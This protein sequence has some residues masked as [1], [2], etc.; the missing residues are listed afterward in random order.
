MNFIEVIGIDVSKK[1]IDA[2]I[3]VSGRSKEFKNT[4]RGLHE[5]LNWSKRHVEDINAV[6][7]VFE[8]TGM[9]S[10]LI[11]TF[12]DAKGCRYFVAPALEIKRSMGIVRGKDDKVD[13]KRIALY[14]F[15]L[16]DELVPSKKHNRS[17][18]QLKSL[19]SLK[20][21][22][23]KQRAAYKGTLKE[24]KRIYKAKDFKTIFDVQQRMICYLTKQ[25]KAIESQIIEIIKKEDELEHNLNLIVS[26]KGIGLQMG[27]TMLIATE[28][29]KKFDTWRKFASYCGVAPFAYQSGTSVKGRTKVSQLANKKIKALVH[30][31]AITAIQH[32]PEMKQYYERRIAAGKSKMSTINI[33]RNKLIARIFSVIKRQTPYVNMMKFAA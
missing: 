19:M 24:Q 16:K 29:F 18:S 15:R 6:L 25:I 23:I 20:A 9:Y 5:F 33:I 17:I 4:R 8:H 10:Y 3:H 7:F 30:M 31:C 11:T 21:K 14:G 1:T 26:I 28:N 13:A 32:N 27:T 2:C 22:L 12:L